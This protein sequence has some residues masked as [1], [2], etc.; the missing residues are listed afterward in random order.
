MMACDVSPVAM[1][2]LLTTKVRIC[3]YFERNVYFSGEI[4]IFVVKVI[5][6]WEEIQSFCA[7]FI[8]K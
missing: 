3:L 5:I 6:F 1:F 7:V 4:I 2:F 8:Q